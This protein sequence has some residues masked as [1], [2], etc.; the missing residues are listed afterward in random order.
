[1]LNYKDSLKDK[2]C[3]AQKSGF[4]N[5]KGWRQFSF[6]LI[7]ANCYVLL[8]FGISGATEREIVAT[9]ELRKRRR[10]RKVNS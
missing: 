1:M 9:F 8:I 4:V 2:D 5:L 6:S 7:F 3:G 10:A